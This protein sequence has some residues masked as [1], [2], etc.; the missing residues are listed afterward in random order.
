[1]HAFILHSCF[2]WPV[3]SLF[4]TEPLALTSD[5]RTAKLLCPVSHFPWPSHALRWLLARAFLALSYQKLRELP[6]AAVHG[7]RTGLPVG[8]SG[9][10][11]C[12]RLLTVP[13]CQN[14][15]QFHEDTATSLGHPL[16]G[17][18]NQCRVGAR[19]GPDLMSSDDDS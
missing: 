6:S 1:M 10:V 11:S 4:S 12:L 17:N 2:S 7:Q 18:L 15:V 3:W 5:P 19:V 8:V 16:H 13:S 9:G 14:N